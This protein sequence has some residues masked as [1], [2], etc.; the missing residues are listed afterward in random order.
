MENEMEKEREISLINLKATRMG[1]ALFR[2][3]R[4]T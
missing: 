2:D 3:L 4:R 1:Q